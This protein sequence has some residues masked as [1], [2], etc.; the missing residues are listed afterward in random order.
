MGD[1]AAAPVG[2]ASTVENGMAALRAL[3]RFW[4]DDAATTAIEYGL[5][6]VLVS[7]AIVVTVNAIG[8]GVEG[9]FT[10]VSSQ[11]ATAGR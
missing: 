11:L 6:A 9:L 3:G 7:V 1:L 2:G 5:I 4:Q 8:V 10:N